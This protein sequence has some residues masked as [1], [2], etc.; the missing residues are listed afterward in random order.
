M[1]VGGYLL[2]IQITLA[3]VELVSYTASCLLSPAITEKT[4]TVLTAQTREQ[5]QDA[6]SGPKSGPL[7]SKCRAAVEACAV[8]LWC[9]C[10]ARVTGC[11]EGFQSRPLSHEPR[12]LY[13]GTLISLA[14]FF[15]QFH[16]KDSGRWA[17]QSPG[18]K[19]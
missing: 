17:R 5:P 11:L 13:L 18:D 8:P 1:A 4:P 15:L 7:D 6:Q 2:R 16:M 12:R 3:C 9:F 10:A 19:A 14:L